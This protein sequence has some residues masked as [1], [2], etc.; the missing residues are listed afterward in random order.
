MSK[1]LQQI[2][3]AEINIK[4]EWFWDAGV[5]ATIGDK[6]NGY[7]EAHMFDTVAEAIDWLHASTR[8]SAKQVR[9]R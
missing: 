6:I 5:T 7:S 2:Y 8:S 3:D 4:L 9:G 1:K